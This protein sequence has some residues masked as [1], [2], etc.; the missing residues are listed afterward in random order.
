MGE[1]FIYRRNPEKKFIP[2]T[3]QNFAESLNM[4]GVKEVRDY[5]GSLVLTHEIVSMTFDWDKEYVNDYVDPITASCYLVGSKEFL[6]YFKSIVAIHENRLSCLQG[7]QETEPV[8]P[9]QLE[10]NAES[11]IVP[12]MKPVSAQK[13]ILSI[14]SSSVRLKCPDLRRQLR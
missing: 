3:I 2:I 13:A 14:L 8:E 4:F 11:G 7:K 6:D 12:Q 10:F 1:P 5:L 9:K